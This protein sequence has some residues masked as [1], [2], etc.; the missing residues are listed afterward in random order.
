MSKVYRVGSIHGTVYLNTAKEVDK[1]KPGCEEPESV[2]CVD[3]AEECNRLLKSEYDSEK[4]LAHV[5][6]LLLDL[7]NGCSIGT[8]A[9]QRAMQYFEENPFPPSNAADR[10]GGRSYGLG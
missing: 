10:D 6:L 9:H 3:A 4:A 5:R 8:P 2:D 1:C 7:L